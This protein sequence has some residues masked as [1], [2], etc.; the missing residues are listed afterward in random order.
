MT[1]ASRDGQELE[2]EAVQGSQLQEALRDAAPMHA[3]QNELLPLRIVVQVLFFEKARAAARSGPGGAH[4]VA[5]GMAGQEGRQTARRPR[6]SK[7][8]RASPA[9]RATTAGARMG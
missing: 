8:S 5:C 9:H 1:D 3:A 4:R 2:E 6:P 7:V